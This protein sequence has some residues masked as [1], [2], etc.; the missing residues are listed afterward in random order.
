[1][2]SCLITVITLNSAH[3]GFREHF[4]SIISP[5]DNVYAVDIIMLNIRQNKPLYVYWDICSYAL[6]QT[7]WTRNKSDYWVHGVMFNNKMYYLPRSMRVA[8]AIKC[9]EWKA[10]E[11]RSKFWRVV[12]L[13]TLWQHIAR[14]GCKTSCN[15]VLNIRLLHS[16]TPGRLYIRSGPNAKVC[17]AAKCVK[18]YMWRDEASLQGTGVGVN[19]HVSLC[20]IWGNEL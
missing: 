11:G 13:S 4:S 9:N 3:L 20:F 1:M 12:I 16:C 15:M 7:C 8:F 17:D 6:A 19:L 14:Q 5:S 10:L 18:D 2:W